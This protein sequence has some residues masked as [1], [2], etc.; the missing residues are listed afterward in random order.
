MP[1][2]FRS[3]VVW[4]L[5]CLRHIHPVAMVG[6]A[7]RRLNY[8]ASLSRNRVLQWLHELRHFRVDEETRLERRIAELV[9]R[10]LSDR[11]WIVELSES[12]R[13][14]ARVDEFTFC[15]AR[16][17]G[18]ENKFQRYDDA[19][20]V[21]AETTIRLAHS[22]GA[23]IGK[24]SFMPLALT[25][26]GAIGLAALGTGIRLSRRRAVSPTKYAVPD[27]LNLFTVLALL[28]R[29]QSDQPTGSAARNELDDA[30]ANV[31]RH[32]FGRENGKPT[33]DLRQV[34]EEWTRRMSA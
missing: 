21:P 19:D 16:I 17:D 22:L 23:G 5:A 9:P 11:S 12:P 33:I 13:G 29:M 30:M 6:V 3:Q 25:I 32:Y 7:Q 10:L 34:A 15:S 27:D 20:L 18:A 2:R 4:W 28:Q 1:A 26:V 8:A 14:E 24:R 31:Q